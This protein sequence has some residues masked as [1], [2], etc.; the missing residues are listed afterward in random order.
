MVSYVCSFNLHAIV[1]GERFR[2]GI[3]R[4]S[5]QNILSKELV[6]CIHLFIVTSIISGADLQVVPELT[7]VLPSDPDGCLII[8]EV[9]V[10][11]CLSPNL[12][13]QCQYGP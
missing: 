1:W 7:A 10:F 12:E 3:G 6:Q 8:S 11:V 2:S 9:T 13:R 4:L 5:V